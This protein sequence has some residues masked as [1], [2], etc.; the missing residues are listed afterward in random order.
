MPIPNALIPIILICDYASGADY[1]TGDF[2]AFAG[3]QIC[4]LLKSNPGH[5]T[6]RQNIRGCSVFLGNCE[7]CEHRVGLNNQRVKTYGCNRSRSKIFESI[8]TGNDVN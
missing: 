5:A 3:G 6:T 8:V 7:R 2:A 1:K 4:A